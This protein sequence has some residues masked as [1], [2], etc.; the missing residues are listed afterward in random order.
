M[1]LRHVDDG[2]AVTDARGGIEP[3]DLHAL[4]AQHGFTLSLRPAAD[5][6]IDCMD[7]VF[8]PPHGGTK[9]MRNWA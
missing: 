4:A 2:A 7:A 1:L 3:D 5:G 6:R 9:L 8:L